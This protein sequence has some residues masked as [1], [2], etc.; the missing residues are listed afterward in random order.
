MS[1]LT[2]EQ[3]IYKS[4]TVKW[5]VDSCFQGNSCW[6]RI[7]IPEFDIFYEDDNKLEIVF[8]G[9]LS[10]EQ[11]IKLVSIHNDNIHLLNE[12]IS[13]LKELKLSNKILS[14]YLIFQY[15][16]ML[17]LNY[18]DHNLNTDIKNAFK[19]AIINIK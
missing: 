8:E 18:F 6:C 9:E 10:E 5:K 13:S 14:E 11:A 1:I 3:A 15:Y 4:L 2:Y 7:I 12:L 19:E 16:Q 17:N